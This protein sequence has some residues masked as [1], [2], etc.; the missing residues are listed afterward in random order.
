LAAFGGAGPFVVCKIAE[1]A[2]IREVFIPGL[3]AVFSAFGIGFSDIG[4]EYTTSLPDGRAETLAAG[5]ELLRGRAQ[6]G[7]AAESAD[8]ADCRLDESVAVEAGGR[9]SLAVT[10]VKPLAHARIVGQFD[11]KTHAALST[12]TRR[13]RIGGGEREV[14]LYRVEEQ[15]EGAA[16]SGPAVL[17]EAFFTCRIEAGWRFDINDAGDIRL[18]RS[19]A[20]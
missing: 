3:A 4:H 15:T 9:R 19:T 2:G 20:L 11:T 1:S 5:R 6:R 8:I 18:S 12:G 13:L 16:A 10:A 14:P 17:E 7:M